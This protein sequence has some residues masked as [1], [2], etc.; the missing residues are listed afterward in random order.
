MME[1][2]PPRSPFTL[3]LAIL[4]RPSALAAWVADEPRVARWA[5]VLVIEV[6]V[7]TAGLLAL[8]GMT[9]P[10]GAT[11]LIAGPG[12]A[13]P[14]VMLGALPVFFGLSL[15][16]SI[17]PRLI[18][19]FLRSLVAVGAPAAVGL[20]LV[21]S[22]AF[23]E[24]QR[25][26]ATA[27]L[28]LVVMGM[29]AGGALTVALL[30]SHRRSEAPPLRWV[31]LAG[32]FLIAGLIW[33]SA[34]LRGTGAA[35][36]AP[37][38]IG[39]ALGLLRPFS[40]LW[41]APWNIALALAARLGLPARGLLALHPVSLDELCLLPLPG[42]SGLL[43]RACAEDV[44]SGAPWL[45]TVAAHPSQGRAARA[46]LE[47]LARG[48]R[49]H[50][51]LFWISADEDGAAWLRQLATDVPRPHPLISAYAAL[52][53]VENPAAWPAAIAAH[54]PALAAAAGQPGG[55]AVQALTESGV[56]LLAASRWPAAMDALRRVPR[57]VG[58]TPDPLWEALG[59]I[60]AWSGR[61]QPMLLQDRAQ[62]LS[63]VWESV[64]TF[65][66]WPARLLDAMAEHLVYLLII[67]HRRG[68]W[69][70]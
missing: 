29:W 61:Q 16:Y 26:P 18:I 44:S 34:P 58:V 1:R 43:V 7:V 45:I 35:L 19:S 39:L 70:V 57:P 68:S 59:A 24:L 51:A 49:A 56:Q 28:A 67:E 60:Q 55:A 40:Y 20:T 46:A 41:E 65:E 54:R 27:L 62:A 66:G 48:P 22:S 13:L 17:G 2:K 4:L 36:L 12:L 3:L 10:L 33:W 38:L 50:P 42:L 37:A 25:D 47:R 53:A 52:A 15:D 6:V 64:G 14:L 63:A 8:L 11:A 21:F 9:L 23:P 30:V 5:A 31:G 32:A 69:L